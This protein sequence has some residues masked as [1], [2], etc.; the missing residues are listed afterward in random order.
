M[1]NRERALIADLRNMYIVCWV[2][3]GCYGMHRALKLKN[4]PLQ[5][6]PYI[7]KEKMVQQ[8]TNNGG[9]IM[10][11]QCLVVSIM[12]WFMLLTNH[13]KFVV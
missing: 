11:Q 2:G 12:E 1:L 8:T 13:Q 6:F 5:D 4:E 3:M 7:L 10:M 9:A